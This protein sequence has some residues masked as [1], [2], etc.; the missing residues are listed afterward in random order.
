MYVHRQVM[1]YGRMML[2]RNGLMEW[3]FG[4]FSRGVTFAS[5]ADFIIPV[6]LQFWRMPSSGM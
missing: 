5:S 4:H 2:A 3:P 1:E 6:V